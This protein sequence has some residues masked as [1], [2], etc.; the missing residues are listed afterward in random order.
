MLATPE[1]LKAHSPALASVSDAALVGVLTAVSA[2]VEG[3]TGPILASSFPATFKVRKANLLDGGFLIGTKYATSVTKIDGVA[4]A[5][6]DGTDYWIDGNEVT[7]PELWPTDEKPFFTVEVDGGLTEVPKDLKH[8]VMSLAAF[9]LSREG[10][11]SV[12]SYS[13]GPRSVTLASASDSSAEV[14]SAQRIVR[15]Y[16]PPRP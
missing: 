2:Y 3:Q 16:T 7:M 12:R 6:V 9:E 15:S 10:G 11:Q 1:E 4:Y 14:I 5:G 8:A 13:L